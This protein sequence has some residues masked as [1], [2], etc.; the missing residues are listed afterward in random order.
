[1]NWWSGWPGASWRSRDAGE[2]EQRRRAEMEPALEPLQRV[3]RDHDRARERLLGARRIPPLD[4]LDE[5]PQTSPD[6]RRL[7][8]MARTRNQRVSRARRLTRGD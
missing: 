7:G 4:G 2:L 1:M 3:A 8:T 6:S 5:L